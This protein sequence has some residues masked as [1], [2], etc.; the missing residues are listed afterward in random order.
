VSRQADMVAGLLS[1]KLKIARALDKDQRL[2]KVLSEHAG[3]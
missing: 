2:E 3:T 1:N